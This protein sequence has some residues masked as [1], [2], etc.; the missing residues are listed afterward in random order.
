ME[1]PRV[2][3]SRPRAMYRVSSV[4]RCVSVPLALCICCALAAR[5]VG[6]ASGSARRLGRSQRA[7][8]TTAGPDRPGPSVQSI[9]VLAFSLSLPRLSVCLSVSAR[10]RQSSLSTARSAVQ[11]DRSST[12]TEMTNI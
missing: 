7:L 6:S 8:G 10:P 3:R 2:T 5:P 12:G 11:C 9:F 1:E 4:C